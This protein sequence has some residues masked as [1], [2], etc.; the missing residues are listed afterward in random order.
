MRQ[1]I[2]AWLRPMV[3][4][5]RGV[6]QEPGVVTLGNSKWCYLQLFLSFS[7]DFP[8]SFPF[9]RPLLTTSVVRLVLLPM[10]TRTTGSMNRQENFRTIGLFMVSS[11]MRTRATRSPTLCSMTLSPPKSEPDVLQS[12]RSKLRFFF[13]SELHSYLL[14][15]KLTEK[16]S[17]SFLHIPTSISIRD[18]LDI[19]C[20]DGHWVAHAA[21]AWGVHGTRIVGI[22]FL[23][24][25]KDIMETLSGPSAENTVVFNHNLCVT[26]CALNSPLNVKFSCSV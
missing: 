12:T 11:T 1:S 16:G 19:G 21:Q 10:E 4:P 9:S 23:P 3:L 15:R 2:R 20:G 6:D 18:A 14:M 7:K 13:C 25:S 5:T 22:D 8:R 17:P 26:F 24:I